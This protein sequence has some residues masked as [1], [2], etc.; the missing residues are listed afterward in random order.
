MMINRT[1]RIAGIMLA[2]GFLFFSCS[3]LAP[4]IEETRDKIDEGDL[5]AA[6]G[7]IDSAIADD[8]QNADAHYYRGLIYYKKAE[9]TASSYD[10][11]EKFAEMASSFSEA[12]SLYAEQGRSPYQSEIDDYRTT[13]WE[14]EFAEAEALFNQ[15]RNPE[16]ALN[17][18]E[19][20]LIIDP[21]NIRAYVLASEVYLNQDQV[22][23]AFEV[24]NEGIETADDIDRETYE[25]HAY[26]ALETGEYD[27]ALNSYETLE[28]LGT[29]NLLNLRH[30][31]VNALKQADR[32]RDAANILEKLI[33]N[34]PDNPD[35]TLSYAKQWYGITT[36]HYEQWIELYREAPQ[37]SETGEEFSNAQQHAER[38][39]SL[40]LEAKELTPQSEEVNTAYAI[41]LQNMASLLSDINSGV[42]DEEYREEIQGMI[43]RYAGSAIEAFEE[44]VEQT[45]DPVYYWESLYQLYSFTNQSEKAEEARNHI[46]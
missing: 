1:T 5:E 11:A 35:Y 40:F 41:F 20:A 32:H 2:F 27:A 44:I 18:L 4:G 45:D 36:N 39:E 26:L 9:Q 37:G 46:E 7:M 13:A 17:N 22:A 28:E 30:G 19:N 34:S 31:L 14:S 42:T 15:E 12:E 8:P 33:E 21:G 24:L 10:R 16:A 3:T 29:E 6:A 43:D 23:Q 38:A 25:E